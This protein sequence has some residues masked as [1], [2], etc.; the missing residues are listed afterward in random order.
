MLELGIDGQM[1]EIPY[2]KSA[3]YKQKKHEYYQEN[4]E[5]LLLDDREKREALKDDSE[6]MA[7]RSEFGKRYYHKNKSVIR[8]REKEHRKIYGSTGAHGITL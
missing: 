8:S 7:K 2:R 3:V 4:R 6:Y 1:H 5:K